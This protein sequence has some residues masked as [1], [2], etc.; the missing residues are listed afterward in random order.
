M[1]ICRDDLIKSIEEWS[2]IYGYQIEDID[3]VV[4][5]HAMNLISSECPA[6]KTQVLDCSSLKNNLDLPEYDTANGYSHSPKGILTIYTMIEPDRAKQYPDIV[7]HVHFLDQTIY[8]QKQ[9]DFKARLTLDDKIQF[10]PEIPTEVTSLYIDFEYSWKDLDQFPMQYLQLVTYACYV[11]AL[12]QIL[13]SFMFTDFTSGA[14]RDLQ[15]ESKNQFVL[16]M[17]LMQKK[18]KRKFIDECDRIMKSFGRFT[19]YE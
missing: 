14:F 1:G 10:V 19:K 15:K 12:D 17:E 3:A 2:K 9:H 16:T 4:D 7:D 5:I 8:L 13:N 11:E 18:V 6:V